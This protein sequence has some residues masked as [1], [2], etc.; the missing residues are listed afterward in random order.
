MDQQFDNA[1]HSLKSLYTKRLE[2]IET[3]HQTTLQNKDSR[4]LQLEAQVKELSRTAEKLAGFRQSIISSFG[5]DDLHEMIPS[6]STT[7]FPQQPKP[8]SKNNS[9]SQ[10]A[11][12]TNLV[13]SEFTSATTS[14]RLFLKQDL[15]G[16]ASSL[17]LVKESQGSSNGGGSLGFLPPSPQ[18]PTTRERGT[19][20]IDGKEFFRNAKEILSSN[21]VCTMKTDYVS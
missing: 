20:A 14:P 7:P 9:F 2:Q 15:N 8:I 12:D 17:G 16:N 4:I 1:L 21:E 13:Q 10:P 5:E 3:D 6:T 18:E 19:T 11:L